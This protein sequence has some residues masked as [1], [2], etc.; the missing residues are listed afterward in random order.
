MIVSWS[1]LALLG[2]YIGLIFIF[3]KI[4]LFHYVIGGIIILWLIDW[5]LTTREPKLTAVRNFDKPVYQHQATTIKVV[6]NNPLNR[7]LLLLVQDEPP[8]E[9]NIKGKTKQLLVVKPFSSCEFTYQVTGDKRGCFNFGNLN[10]RYSG[11]LR[12]FTYQYQ[13]P[14]QEPLAVF[15]NLNKIGDYRFGQQTKTELAGIHRQR[16][17]SMNGEFSQLRDFVAGDDYRKIN[18]KVSAHYGK[19]IVNE[20]EPEKDQNIFLCFD[21]GRMLFDQVDS[22]N[23]RMDCIL[24]SALYLAYNIVN[25]GDMV[26]AISFSS[27]VERYVPIGKGKTHLQLLVNQLYDLQAEMLES[28]YREA[29]RFLNSRINKRSLFFIYTDINDPESARDLINYLKILSKH[30]LVVCVLLKKECLSELADC[31]I[32]DETTAYLK[33]TAL[34]LLA[35]REKLVRILSLNNI[36]ILEVEPSNISQTVVQHYLLLKQQGSI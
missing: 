20:Y 26:G 21:A 17:F 23:N 1:F 22:K 5:F 30:H 3:P 33:S 34:E 2:C 36:K 10:L 6:I 32:T 35:E 8:F 9:V 16:I 31:Q 29:F 27:K 15:P 19:P 28:D 12:L 4:A 11:R 18:W 25:H 14:L 24:D 13:I 7:S